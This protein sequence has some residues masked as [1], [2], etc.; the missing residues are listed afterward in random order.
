MDAD[1]ED[2]YNFYLLESSIDPM[3]TRIIISRRNFT[4]FSGSDENL[5][6]NLTDSAIQTPEALPS[7][8]LVGQS[9]IK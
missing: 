4:F 1:N 9:G 3:H 6:D 2:Y 8:S 7:T 5:T